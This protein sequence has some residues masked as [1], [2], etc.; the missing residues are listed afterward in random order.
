MFFINPRKRNIQKVFGI[1]NE[2]D[3]SHADFFYGIDYKTLV[4]YIEQSNEMW[5]NRSI[6]HLIAFL[7]EEDL[8]N[9][10]LNDSDLK[11]KIIQKHTEL[12]HSGL[13]DIWNNEFSFHQKEKTAVSELV[14]FLV[15]NFMKKQ[16]VFSKIKLI[17]IKQYFSYQLDFN[18]IECFELKDD[19][20]RQHIRMIAIHDTFL[21]FQEISNHYYQEKIDFN[22]NFENYDFSIGFENNL[23]KAINNYDLFKNKMIEKPIEAFTKNNQTTKTMLNIGPFIDFKSLYGMAIF[24]NMPEYV[25]DYIICVSRKTATSPSDE[26]YLSV[27]D[28]NKHA[29]ADFGIYEEIVSKLS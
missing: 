16:P 8:S 22:N 25:D 24:I 13:Y 19:N 21:F 29:D 3:L 2:I 15:D 5:N 14:G 28:I 18:K 12:I 26:L 10:I 7:L 27:Y 9:K 23:R 20:F 1:K 17:S 4:K 11:N 6:S